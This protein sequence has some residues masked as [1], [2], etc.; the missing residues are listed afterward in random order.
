MRGWG[1]AGTSTGTGAGAGDGYCN[2]RGD[3]CMQQL[4]DA[5]LASTGRTSDDES[6]DWVSS[7]V[8]PWLEQA[9]TTPTMLV[10]LSLSAAK[11]RTRYLGRP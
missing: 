9:A 6:V 1:E 10:P 5:R 11:E 4:I 3:A 8:T 7:L 2:G